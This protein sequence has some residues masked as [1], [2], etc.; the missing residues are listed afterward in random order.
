MFG[1]M[2]GVKRYLGC[3]GLVFIAASLSFSVFGEQEGIC[4]DC[5]KGDSFGT[6]IQNMKKLTCE[7]QLNRPECKNVPHI[8]RPN[9]DKLPKYPGAGI[10][11]LCFSMH[12]GV[13]T[14]SALSVHK[15]LAASK[16]VGAGTSLVRF[17]PW[18]AAAVAA[19]GAAYLAVKYHNMVSKVRREAT[20]RGLDPK[21][22][23]GIKKQARQEIT[24]S[25]GKRLYDILYGDS[26]CYNVATQVARACGLMAGIG[27]TAGVGGSVS[28]ALAG[29]AATGTSIGA[30]SGAV[31]GGLG[32]YVVPQSIMPALA[33]QYTEVQHDVQKRI[34]AA[35]DQEPPSATEQ[36]DQLLQEASQ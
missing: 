16:A 9:C 15:L 34:Q 24:L 28:L 19:G 21:D 36:V 20:Q 17:V 11:G 1:L 2:D 10:V 14:A 5:V 7:A 32:G 8:L 25:L 27:A 33:A 23:E 26:H 3:V 12:F 6:E 35:K 4:V 29:A 31:L 18:V 13:L 22:T 30:A